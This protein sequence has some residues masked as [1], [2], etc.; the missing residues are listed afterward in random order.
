MTAKKLIYYKIQ[1]KNILIFFLHSSFLFY[2]F[3]LKLFF[4]Y[5]MNASPQTH[6]YD[7]TGKYVRARPTAK[8]TLQIT[9]FKK[10]FTFL[11]RL[12]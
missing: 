1:H 2:S 5:K 8:L 10:P 7:D 6:A 11:L 9:L 4:L 12:L 3:A